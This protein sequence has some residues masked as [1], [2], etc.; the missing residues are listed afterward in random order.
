M[1]YSGRLGR[2]SDA[3]MFVATTEQ[4]H[5]QCID[6]ENAKSWKERREALREQLSSLSKHLANDSNDADLTHEAATAEDLNYHIVAPCIQLSSQLRKGCPKY[7]ELPTIKDLSKCDLIK[8]MEDFLV[9]SRNRKWAGNELREKL[10]SYIDS[11]HSERIKDLSTD[12]IIKCLI[13][14]TYKLA[15]L[16]MYKNRL[17]ELKE[18][19]FKSLEQYIEKFAH[20]LSFLEVTSIIHEGSEMAL[21]DV[22][23]YGKKMFYEGALAKN[24]KVLFYMKAQTETLRNMAGYLLENEVILAQEAKEL[25]RAE[26]TQYHLTLASETVFPKKGDPGKLKCVLHPKGNHL[27]NECKLKKKIKQVNKQS[28]PSHL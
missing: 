10:M 2:R 7:K 18:I 17:K 21:E 15:E 19:N 11:R 14:E 23:L 9:L 5:I 25:V 6:Q 26:K 3:E 20:F 4:E 22:E 12:K 1:E 24:K 8:W 28:F 13:K 16:Q 27:E